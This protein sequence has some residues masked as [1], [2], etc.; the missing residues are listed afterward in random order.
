MLVVGRWS[1]AIGVCLDCGLRGLARLEGE[2]GQAF[3][4]VQV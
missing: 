3:Y 4:F 1:Q 2:S